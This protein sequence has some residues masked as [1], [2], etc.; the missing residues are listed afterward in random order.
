MAVVLNG[1]VKLDYQM[2]ASDCISY[3]NTDYVIEKSL[4]EYISAILDTDEWGYIY[5]YNEN[6]GSEFCLEY[7]H[8]T[9]I[10]IPEISVLE[11]AFKKTVFDAEYC[12]GW[13]RGD[14]SLMIK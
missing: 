9:L 6:G 5:I 10:T 12:G 3:Y 13:S 7:S 11:E 2:T 4:Y 14:W 1:L 8:G